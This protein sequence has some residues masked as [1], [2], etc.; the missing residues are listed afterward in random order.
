[1]EVV[2]AGGERNDFQYSLAH[3]VRF[4]SNAAGFAG[5]AIHVE[6]PPNDELAPI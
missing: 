5:G 3:I 1:M 2:G 6:F 4:D